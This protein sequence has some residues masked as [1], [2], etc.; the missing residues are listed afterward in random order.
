MRFTLP[1]ALA[2]FL[3]SSLSAKTQTTPPARPSEKAPPPQSSTVPPLFLF[4][5]NAP[6][7]GSQPPTLLSQPTPDFTHCAD[8]K[9]AGVLVKLVIEPNGSPS[10][11]EVPFASKDKCIDQVAR[12]AAQQY[13]FTPAQQG[14]QPFATHV[15]FEIEIHPSGTVPPRLIRA[16][17]PN[18]PDTAHGHFNVTVKVYLDVD[19]VGIPKNARVTSAT[20]PHFDENALAA[21]KQYLFWP[22]MKSGRP[23]E[24]P[25]YIDV[26]FQKF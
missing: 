17:D 16:V 5:P 1:T 6:P 23:I 2:I 12:D 19:S 18:M 11:I 24:F 15:A 25:I 8:Q 26:N 3:T 20:N 22:A 21:V 4:V 14:G 10:H 9:T 7:P 13:R